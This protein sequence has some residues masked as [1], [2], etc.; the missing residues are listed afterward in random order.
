MSSLKRSYSKE[1]RS[2]YSRSAS[3]DNN[4]I[5]H[6]RLTTFDRPLS[7]RLMDRDFLRPSLPLSFG[8]PLGF[9]FRSR[10]FFDDFDRP[11]RWRFLDD[12]FFDD[13]FLPLDF[14][15]RSFDIGRP[16][17]LQHRSFESSSSVSRNIPVQYTPSSTGNRA[18]VYSTMENNSNWDSNRS[19]QNF[20]GKSISLDDPHRTRRET[21]RTCSF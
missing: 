4:S 10:R 5:G 6:R 1:S 2:Y 14:G 7:S 17:P 21:R 3:A 15:M 18:Q 12:G 20:A 11:F 13:D 9:G 16:L 8:D 19:G